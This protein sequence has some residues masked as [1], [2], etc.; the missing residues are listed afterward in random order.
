MGKLIASEKVVFL[1]DPIKA[2]PKGTIATDAQLS[3]I[4]RFVDFGCLVY[5]K[6]WADCSS[7]IDSPYN[8][9]QLYKSILQYRYRNA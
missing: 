1:Q 5:A 9:L 3:K 6:W 2:L 7:A 4:R 8:D